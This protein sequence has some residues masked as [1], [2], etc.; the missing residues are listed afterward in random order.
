MNIWGNTLQYYACRKTIAVKIVLVSFFFLGVGT[1]N[2]F[3][4]PPPVPSVAKCLINV[5]AYC[6]ELG[7]IPLVTIKAI[8]T[9]AAAERHHIRQ[10]IGNMRRLSCVGEAGGALEAKIGITPKAE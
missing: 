7:P 1:K 4:V 10:V 8:F 6:T 2:K 3:G 9:E 5:V